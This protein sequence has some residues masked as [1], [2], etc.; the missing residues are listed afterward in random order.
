MGPVIKETE[1]DSDGQEISELT[2]RRSS[3]DEWKAI[4]R[5]NI[6]QLLQALL[7]SSQ[8]WRAAPL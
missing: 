1:V 7:L 4:C 2:T 3:R 8:E 6:F 5:V